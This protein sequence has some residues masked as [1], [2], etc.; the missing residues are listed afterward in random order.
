MAWVTIYWVPARSS[1]EPIRPEIPPPT[2]FSS[3]AFEL[4]SQMS[5]P[6][7]KPIKQPAQVSLRRTNASL[8]PAS[9]DEAKIESRY[10]SDLFK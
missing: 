5:T 4:P 8:A 2:K 9:L 6:R 10:A 1:T 3:A 7:L